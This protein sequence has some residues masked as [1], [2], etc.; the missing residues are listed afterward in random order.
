MVG[1]DGVV[2]AP[3]E[4]DA[5][6]IEIRDVRPRA[7]SGMTASVNAETARAPAI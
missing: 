6:A 4:N 3:A 1:D 2:T 7:A 5:A